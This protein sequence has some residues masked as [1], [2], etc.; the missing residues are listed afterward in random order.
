M[1]Q[2]ALIHDVP[3][4]TWVKL[5]A[6]GRS[7]NVSRYAGETCS[8]LKGG[9]VEIIGTDPEFGV[10]VRYSL[11][12]GSRAAGAL[13]HNGALVFLPPET[14]KSWPTQGEV[15]R[16]MSVEAD[17]RVAAVKRLMRETE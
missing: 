15:T 7:D 11:P 17:R 3:D 16:A 5:A 13:C 1:K 4:Y 10:L 8:L 2:I 9:Q 6:S 12:A 14:V